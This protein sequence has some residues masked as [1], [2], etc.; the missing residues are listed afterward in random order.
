MPARSIFA[1]TDASG[2]STS[3]YSE[4]W[5]RAFEFGARDARRCGAPASA[6]AAGIFGQRA[7]QHRRRRL[8]G[9]GVRARRIE[10]VRARSSDRRRACAAADRACRSAPSRRRRRDAATLL[11][12]AANAAPTRARASARAIERETRLVGRADAD[13][14]AAQRDRDALARGRVAQQLARACTK[15]GGSVDRDVRRCRCRAAA[16]RSRP[17]A[18]SAGGVELAP[19]AP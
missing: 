17:A 12:S 11:H 18:A 5:S 10:H 9:I 19:A 8:R 2:T 15:S 13:R 1:S 14:V 4:S 16:L 3:A 7:M 6:A